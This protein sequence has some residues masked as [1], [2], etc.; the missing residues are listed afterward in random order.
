PKP[1]VDAD[2]FLDAPVAKTH[3][4]AVVSLGIKNLVGILSDEYKYVHHRDD[5]HQKLA[6]LLKVIKPGLTVI[7]GIV[8]GEGQGPANVERVNWGVVIAG[9]E[10]V[11]TDAVGARAM[12]YDPQEV[13]S[14][15]IAAAEGIGEAD[16]SKIEI[17]GE[18]LASVERRFKRAILNPTGFYPFDV[19]TSGWCDGCRAWMGA[20]LDGWA[21][22]GTFR[23]IAERKKVTIGVG[24]RVEIPDI[25]DR[26]RQ[27]PVIVFGDCAP[28]E[29]KKHPGVIHIPGCPPTVNLIPDFEGALRKYGVSI[30]EIQKEK[31]V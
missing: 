11:A 27:G 28:D 15:R 16:L 6:D 4:A 17:L 7:D 24:C 19:F 18:P 31:Y 21:K 1:V 20:C 14:V 5:L 23:K 8:A 12:G 9:D 3:V 13:H 22:D 2:L 29:T 10:V 25:E 26:I 30:E